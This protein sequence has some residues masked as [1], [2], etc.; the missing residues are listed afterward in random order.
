MGQLEHSSMQYADA[1]AP[2]GTTVALDD[3][4]QIAVVDTANRDKPALMLL[5]GLQDEA[6]SWQR[7]V[8]LLRDRFRIIAPDLPGFGRSDKRARRYTIPFL[9]DAVL[10]TAT[11]LGVGQAVYAG[12][13]LGAM[14]AEY[15]A[16]TQAPRVTRLV[17][18]SG[19]LSITKQPPS[20]GG[21]LINRVFADRAERAYFDK[22]RADPNAAFETLRAY[23]HDLDG[24]PEAQRTFLFRRVNARV[25]DEAQRR[26]AFSIRANM[27]LF[28]VRNLAMIRRGV[29]KLG[30]PVSVVWGANDAIFPTANGPARKAL[31]AGAEYIEL[32]DCGHLPQQER[33]DDMAAVLRGTLRRR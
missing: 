25:N 13:S 22:L 29:P 31:Q 15:I 11:R 14:I 33:P 27:A 12:N 17:L 9:A 23:Y 18:I 2:Y 16:L 10:Q 1:L 26:A 6:D 32:P 21:S 4:T 8:P 30:M 7:L 3:D 5:H 20:S 24:L 19:T 28:F